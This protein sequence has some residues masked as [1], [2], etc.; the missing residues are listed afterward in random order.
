M[1]AGGKRSAVAWHRRAGKDSF[2]VNFTAYAAVQRV[3]TYWHMAPKQTQVRRLMWDGIDGQGRRIIDQAFPHAIRKRTVDN[4]MKIELLNGSIW[5][6]VGSDSYDMLVGSNPVGLVLS[7]Y[8]LADPKA[9]Q[10]LSPILLENKGWMMAISTFRGRNH[11][12]SMWE[13]FKDNPNAFAE[14]LTVEDTSREDGTR[15]ITDEMLDEERRNGVSESTI[16]QEY[17]GSP[18]GGLEGAF[19]NAELS[20]MRL[21]KRIGLFPHDPAKP[22]VSVWDIGR[23][24]TSI[25]IFQRNQMT[26]NP[27][28]V[29]YIG[30]KNRGLPYFAKKLKESPYHFVEHWG[31]HDIDRVD[32]TIDNNRMN[33]AKG[34]GIDF[35]VC[36]KVPLEDGIEGARVFLNLLSVNATESTQEAISAWQSYR[37]DENDQSMRVTADKVG[38]KWASHASDMLRYAAI[39][40]P[41]VSKLDNYSLFSEQSFKVKRALS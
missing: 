7:E 20:K 11:F 37:R 24:M 31:P 9:W 19:Y 35:D 23:D 27:V 4:E 26:G 34:L 39:V 29:D 17:Y 5:Q 30:E 22:C 8:A 21:D 18:D 33:V 40:W 16:A 10:Y 25:G 1:A 13:A 36:P 6:C 2:A 3:G 14:N 28:M 41:M 12:Y 15:I 32:W 38:P